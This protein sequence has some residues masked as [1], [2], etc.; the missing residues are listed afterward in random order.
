MRHPR[1]RGGPGIRYL[2]GRREFIG[3]GIGFALW[4]LSGTAR[5]AAGSLPGTTRSA[6]AASPYVYVSPLKSDG[7]E[8]SCHAEVWYAWLDGAA[9][10]TVSSEGW[11]ARSI[12]RGLDR[13]RIWVGDHG[14]LK[15]LNSGSTAFRKGPS[16]EARAEK[17]SDSALLERVLSVY[18]QKYPEEIEKWRTRMREGHAEGTRVLIR[19]RPIR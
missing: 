19:Y 16:F 1:R 15:G 14:H 7:S 5:A 4:P 13:A 12:D 2:I 11:K 6:L 8:S 10:V 18:D 9:V 17:L 3:A